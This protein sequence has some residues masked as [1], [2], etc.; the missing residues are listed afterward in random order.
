[1]WLW[2]WLRL[3]LWLWL[4]RA[5]ECKRVSASCE[6]SSTRVIE[7]GVVGPMTA[8]LEGRAYGRGSSKVQDV[9]DC[10]VVDGRRGGHPHTTEKH[11]QGLGHLNAHA[12][13]GNDD[14]GRG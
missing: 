7:W 12:G 6:Y 10:K 1:M 5:G 4:W 3:R 9:Q 8:R 11:T 14:E 13:Q 2:L